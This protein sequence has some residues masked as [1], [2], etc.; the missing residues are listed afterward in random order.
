MKWW[1]AEKTITNKSLILNPKDPHLTHTAITVIIVLT[2][3][4]QKY[5]NEIM[6]FR[7]CGL[8]ERVDETKCH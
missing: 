3:L 7:W 4:V 1:M 5:L 8:Y 6:S 2:F